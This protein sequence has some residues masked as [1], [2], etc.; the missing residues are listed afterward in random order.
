MT[1]FGAFLLS[2]GSCNITLTSLAACAPSLEPAQILLLARCRVRE[3]LLLATPAP[4][5]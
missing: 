3:V 1:Q 5:P 4:S 2:L